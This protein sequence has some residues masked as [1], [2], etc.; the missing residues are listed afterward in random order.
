M[1]T[2]CV[3]VQIYS[4]FKKK[5]NWIK[6]VGS[7][8]LKWSKIAEW[9][10]KMCVWTNEKKRKPI[11]TW[12]LWQCDVHIALFLD[13]LNLFFHK[14][15]KNATKKLI[16][17]LFCHNLCV[18]F[19]GPLNQVG[20]SLSDLRGRWNHFILIDSVEMKFWE[21]DS[22]LNC[23]RSRIKDWNFQLNSSQNQTLRSESIVWKSGL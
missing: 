10:D 1:T 5:L 23:I 22:G 7:A 17:P 11:N 3:L 21:I 20:V 15:M 9:R 8:V 6:G 13:I 2:D 12:Q 16:K 19:C 18:I 4:F 14:N